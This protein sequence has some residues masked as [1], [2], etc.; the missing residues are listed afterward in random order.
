MQENDLTSVQIVY[1]EE[2]Q[3]A[4]EWICQS[5]GLQ[6]KPMQ[7]SGLLIDQNCLN[8]PTI[9]LKSQHS[10]FCRYTKYVDGCARLILHKHPRITTKAVKKQTLFAGNST[11]DRSIMLCLCFA[12]IQKS[13][14]NGEHVFTTITGKAINV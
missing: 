3:A 5:F 1:T 14:V 10:C 13:K 4:A 6:Y 2:T 9:L 12:F 8:F 11:E 7:I